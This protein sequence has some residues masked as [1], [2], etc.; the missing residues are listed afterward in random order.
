MQ[1]TADRDTSTIF[2]PWYILILIILDSYWIH[3]G[4]GW[5]RNIHW[6]CSKR[7]PCEPCDI[8]HDHDALRHKCGILW[9][10]SNSWSWSFGSAGGE[11]RHNRGSVWLEVEAFLYRA[12]SKLSICSL[13]WL[14]FMVLRWWVSYMA[15]AWTVQG[16]WQA[17]SCHIIK[18]G[19]CPPN[20]GSLRLGCSILA[21]F[22]M[23]KFGSIW[24]HHLLSDPSI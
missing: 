13:N 1:M 11:G 21:W 7:I 18:L 8:L 16:V 5:I 14:S 3:I 10:H 20:K 15:V 6:T 19:L 12:V 22:V 2:E 4:F 23:C 17:L 24:H 9:L